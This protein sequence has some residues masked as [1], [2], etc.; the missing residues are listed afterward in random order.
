MKATY[1]RTEMEPTD[2]NSQETSRFV[3]D[4]VGPDWWKINHTM[5]TG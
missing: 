1:L 5:I 3:A 4:G 2:E